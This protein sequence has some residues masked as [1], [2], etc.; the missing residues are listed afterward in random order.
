MPK[1]ILTKTLALLTFA[2]LSGNYS[3]PL[4]IRFFCIYFM[5]S[6]TH[7]QGGTGII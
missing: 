2:L 3:V 4:L 1:V 5:V 7:P 6:S